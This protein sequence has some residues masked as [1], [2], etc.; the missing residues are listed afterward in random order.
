MVFEVQLALV[1]RQSAA[2]LGHALKKLFARAPTHFRHA[3]EIFEA[4]CTF[5]HLLGGASAAIA[6]T[7][8]EQHFLMHVG[9]TMLVERGV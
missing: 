6:V 5:A 3:C 7:H 4:P 1:H 8:R 9:L 2:L